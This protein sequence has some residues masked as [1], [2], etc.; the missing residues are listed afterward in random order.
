MRLQQAN[1]HI[2]CPTATR[3]SCDSVCVAPYMCHTL[4]GSP[5]LLGGWG[6][7]KGRDSVLCEAVRLVS[8]NERRTVGMR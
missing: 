7:K 3:L 4:A 8:E 5:A 2:G 6:S 1:A